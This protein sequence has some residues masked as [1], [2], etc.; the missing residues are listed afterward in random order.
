[1]DIAENVEVDGGGD[2]CKNRTVKKLPRSENSSGTTGY[3][4]SNAKQAVSN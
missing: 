4:T 1:M 3:L 2:D